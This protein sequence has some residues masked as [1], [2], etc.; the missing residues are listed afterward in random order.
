MVEGSCVQGRLIHRAEKKEQNSTEQKEQN[1][2]AC[3]VGVALL[4]D[5]EKLKD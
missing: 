5:A 2:I 1:S 3:Y 4:N